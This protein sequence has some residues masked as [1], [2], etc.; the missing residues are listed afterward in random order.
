MDGL[1]STY[2]SQITAFQSE[3]ENYDQ[4]YQ[5]GGL[6]CLAHFLCSNCSRS[7]NTFRDDTA[8]VDALKK[9]LCQCRQQAHHRRKPYVD[10]LHCKQASNTPE[11]AI[12]G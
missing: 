8:T 10:I 9:E 12:D 6:Y 5:I 3:Y 1:A 4:S 7:S 11:R 2:S